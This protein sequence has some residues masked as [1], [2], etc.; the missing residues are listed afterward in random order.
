MSDLGLHPS[1]TNPSLAQRA[2][3]ARDA[4]R[5]AAQASVGAEFAQRVRQHRNGEP[6]PVESNFFAIEPTSINTAVGEE[7]TLRRHLRKMRS[8]LR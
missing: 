5:D 8:H 6:P 2:L 3:A 1:T 7:F 4:E